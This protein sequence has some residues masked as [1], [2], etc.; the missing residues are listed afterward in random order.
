MRSFI[1]HIID[2]FYFPLIARW[3]PR[4][5]FRYLA[6]G[7]TSTTIDLVI[8][9]LSYHFIL[10]EQMVH[11]PFVTISGY[12]AAFLI[13]FCV[14]FPIGFMLSRYVVFPESHIRGRIQLIRYFFIVGCC[15]LFNYV[16]LHYFVEVW[17][18]YPTI[19]KCL[20]TVIVACFSYFMQKYFTFRMKA[21]IHAAD[22]ANHR[23]NKKSS[24]KETSQTKIWEKRSQVKK[25]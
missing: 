18:I 8:F 16:F 17:H 19:A 14:S 1:L 11:L 24:S 5:T 22:R 2:F 9:Y 23:S 20:I 6:C 25:C 13:A 21:E 10:K 4:R 7:G 15:V 3:I 12:I